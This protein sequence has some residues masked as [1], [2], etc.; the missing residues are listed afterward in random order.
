MLLDTI[1]ILCRVS[2]KSGK[3]GENH[4]NPFCMKNVGE[5]QGERSS[6]FG[7]HPVMD[8]NDLGAVLMLC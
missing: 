4:G 2:A 1:Y 8:N 6:K 5:N 7:R 3:S